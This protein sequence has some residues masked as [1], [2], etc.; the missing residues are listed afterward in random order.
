MDRDSDEDEDDENDCVERGDIDYVECGVD[1]TFVVMKR[2]VIF[3]T[4][5]NNYG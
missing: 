2:G 1:H 3:V 4:G 5:R